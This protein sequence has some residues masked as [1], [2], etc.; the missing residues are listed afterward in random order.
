MAKVTQSRSDL[1]EHL[2]EQLG[3]MIKSC[4]AYD[5]GDTAE[6]KRL[7]VSMR[8]LLHDTKVSHSLLS[9]L[10]LKTI[11]FLN[12]ATPIQDGEKRAILAFLQTK[13]TVND[14]LTITGQHH[15]L[16]SHRPEGW[17]RARK[18]MFPD[19]WNQTVLTDTAGRRFT[20]RVLVTEVANT[21][22]GAH[23]GPGLDRSYAALS[24]DNSI[25]CA[26]GQLSGDLVQIDKSE[27]AS[28]RQ[29]AHELVVSIADR[30]PHLMPK[31]PTYNAS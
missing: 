27:L 21:D 1:Q 8:V 22:G 14:D 5:D 28:I 9:Q 15:P 30:V 12:T 7:A 16:L 23:V 20:R 6:A 10:G 3:F 19:W 26:V 31:H 18:R 13:L 11:G 29:I 25:G 24:R 17:P 2:R 4:R